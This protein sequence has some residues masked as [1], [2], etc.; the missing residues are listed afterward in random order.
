MALRVQH[1]AISE[2]ATVVAIAAYAVLFRPRLAKA[3]TGKI[4]RKPRRIAQVEF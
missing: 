3:D 1:W 4:G 2:A